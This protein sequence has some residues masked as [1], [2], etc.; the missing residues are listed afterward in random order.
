MKKILI[1]SIIILIVAIGA[2]IAFFMNSMDAAEEQLSPEEYMETGGSEENAEEVTEEEKTEL[3]EVLDGIEKEKL[4]LNIHEDST[5][6]EAVKVMHEM[7]HQKVRAEE[8]WGRVPM[9]PETIDQVY[10]V[11]SNSN[12][13]NK[14]ELLLIAE[15]WKDGN[16]DAA[17]FDH[18]YLWSLQGGTIGK[19]YENL[20]INEEIQYIKDSFYEK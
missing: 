6:E 5:Q 17:H 8:K 4:K 1:V 7:V 15:S 2:G 9:H 13:D 3:E 12:F 16:F 20:P 10:N 18:N 14:H 11:I 19:A